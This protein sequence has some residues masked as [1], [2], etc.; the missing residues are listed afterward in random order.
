MSLAD[1]PVGAF[2]L[3]IG[4]NSTLDPVLVALHRDGP[5]GALLHIRRAGQARRKVLVSIAGVNCAGPKS[6]GETLI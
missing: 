5:T 6:S 1:G 3:S 2:R 4:G